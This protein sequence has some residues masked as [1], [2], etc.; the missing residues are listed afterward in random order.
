MPLHTYQADWLSSMREQEEFRPLQGQMVLFRLS[1][2]F[3]LLAEIFP[4]LLVKVH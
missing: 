2:P 3:R 4:S 1:E